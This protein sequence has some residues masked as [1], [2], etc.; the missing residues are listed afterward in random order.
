[1]SPEQIREIA[2]GEVKKNELTGFSAALTFSEVFH[3]LDRAVRILEAAGFA[4]EDRRPTH[5]HL[6]RGGSYCAV[7]SGFVQTETPLV[8]MAL[9]QIY[10]AQDGSWWVRPVSEFEDG[11]FARL[12]QSQ[13]ERG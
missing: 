4:I 12:T 10:V 9:V 2:N 3:S 5:K 7:A 6:K 8:D 11:R 13:G 1:M